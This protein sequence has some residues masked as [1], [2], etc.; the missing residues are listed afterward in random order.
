MQR[1]ILILILIGFSILTGLAL[2][3]HGYWG[4]FEPQ[5]KSFAG[6]QVLVDLVIALGLF[7]VW[8]FRDAKASGR[9]PWPWLVITLTVGSF[10]PLLYLLTRK[11]V[12]GA[13]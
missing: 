1:A 11:N 10:G 12:S 13:Q 3:Q 4:I 5:L 9:N 7:L 6:A 8:M 2:W